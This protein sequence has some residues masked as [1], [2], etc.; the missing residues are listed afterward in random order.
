MECRG[1]PCC[2]SLH[3]DFL[4]KRGREYAG[5]ILEGVYY[6]LALT[7]WNP[8][9]ISIVVKNKATWMSLGMFIYILLLPYSQKY[10]LM[11]ITAL[12]RLLDTYRR[13]ASALLVS[14]TMGNSQE[15]L[16]VKRATV[17][18]FTSFL[19]QKN[20]FVKHWLSVARYPT[21]AALVWPW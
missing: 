10:I 13:G 18:G 9:K 21:T 19:C 2:I 1:T 6:A 8:E 12:R 14:T 20:G 5:K 15:P 16:T 4:F 17:Q 3:L 7:F 11:A